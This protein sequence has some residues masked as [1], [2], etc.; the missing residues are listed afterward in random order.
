MS[1]AA[2]AVTKV[3]QDAEKPIERNI[4]AQQIVD[5]GKSMRALTASGLTRR[6]VIALVHDLAPSVS[7][8]V[9]R[10]VLDGLGELERQFVRP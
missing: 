6:A 8:T 2:V 4:L 3:V 1:K 9:I 10:T 5:I 7:K